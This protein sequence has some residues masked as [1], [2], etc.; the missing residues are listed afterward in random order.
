[1]YTLVGTDI[2]I[3]VISN[4]SSSHTEFVNVI[5]RLFNVL[6]NELQKESLPNI[7]VAIELWHDNYAL[8]ALEEG[9]EGGER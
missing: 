3:L 2:I 4:H 8:Y 1:M 7:H 9:E 6:S 5:A